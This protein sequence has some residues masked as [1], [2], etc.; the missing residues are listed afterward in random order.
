VDVIATPTAPTPAFKLGE[1]NTDPLKM[2]LE[3]V[4]TVPANIAGIPGI[5]VPAGTVLRDGVK[6]PVGVQF[7]ANHF[8]E[9]HLFAIGKAVEKI[10]QP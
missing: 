5:S 7:V 3:D 10:T 8:H 9:A 4:F 2:Y 6:L 1:K